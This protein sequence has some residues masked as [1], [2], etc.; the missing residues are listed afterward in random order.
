MEQE[1][2]LEKEEKILLIA[3]IDATIDDGILTQSKIRKLFDIEYHKI[4]KIISHME[5][6]NIIEWTN[7]SRPKKYKISNDSWQEIQT[8]ILQDEKIGEEEF[9]EVII[10]Y[11]RKKDAYEKISSKED[12]LL[13]EVIDYMINRNEITR[14]EINQQFKTG[15]N[16]AERILEQLEAR[17]MISSITSYKT[18][19]VLATKENLKKHR[20]SMI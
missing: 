10:S 3:I 9:N 17:N 19:K 8:K 11:Q 4:V 16:R 7:C 5:T 1:N 20:D 18:R 14:S 12:P 6:L 2:I 13:I 15:Y